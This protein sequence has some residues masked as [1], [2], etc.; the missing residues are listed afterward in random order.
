MKIACIYTV[1]SYFEVDKPFSHA[2]EVPLG[3][4]IIITVLLAHGHD[5]ELFVVTPDT[6]LDNTISKYVLEQ[7][8]KLICYTAYNHRFEP[9]F[10]RM[11]KLNYH[12][13]YW[14]KNLISR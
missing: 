6:D 9:N 3:I 2:T 12:T 4:S 5:V 13:N 10:V 7:K 14:I 8:P 11:K 1:D